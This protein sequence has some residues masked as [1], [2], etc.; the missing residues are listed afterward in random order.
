MGDVLKRAFIPNNPSSFRY[1]R[2][3]VV[4]QWFIDNPIAIKTKRNG[5]IRAAPNLCN[6]LPMLV[7][8]HAEIAEDGLIVMSKV[9]WAGG[10]LLLK[11]S[12]GPLSLLPT[13]FCYW[14]NHN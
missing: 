10:V 3:R 12:F 11:D 2:K 4:P 9:L 14:L 6:E 13:F 8:L 1:I 7:K 5:W